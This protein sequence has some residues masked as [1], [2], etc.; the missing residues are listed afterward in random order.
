MTVYSPEPPRR[1]LIVHHT[2]DNVE[3]DRV[4]DTSPQRIDGKVIGDVDFGYDGVVGT[5]AR[6]SN[7]SSAVKITALT[8][9]MPLDEMHASLW[10][11]SEFP[12]EVTSQNLYARITI[13]GT[14]HT[15]SHVSG[16]ETDEWQYGSLDFDGTTARLRYGKR[17]AEPKVVDSVEDVGTVDDYELTFYTNGFGYVDDTRVYR[18][19][20]TREQD[21]RLW[22]IGGQHNSIEDYGEEWDTGGIPYRGDNRRFAGTLGEADDYVYRQLDHLLEARHID[23]ASG[24]QLDDIGALAGIQRNENESDDH[25]RARIQATIVAARSSGTHRDVLHATST[26]VGVPVERIKTE[27]AWEGGVNEPAKANIYLEERDVNNSPF[28]QSELNEL[29]GETVLAGHEVDVIETAANPFTVI[30]DSQ[31][32]DADV[33]LTSD[34]LATGGALTSDI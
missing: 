23:S 5:A 2:Y 1:E 3:L 30:N 27:Y 15:L 9:Q 6:M 24:S 17:N 26:I 22:S 12:V 14:E 32:N 10:G 8:E 31:V 21:E 16:E 20:L 18:T 25:Y 7:N 28:T 29:I 34:S 33:G 4:I 11:R 13:D 19:S